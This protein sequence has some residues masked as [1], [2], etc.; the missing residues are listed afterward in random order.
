MP[1]KCDGAYVS[2]NCTLKCQ[3]FINR[4]YNGI[5]SVIPFHIFASSAAGPQQTRS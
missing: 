1:T 2:T 5:A 3:V 4:V